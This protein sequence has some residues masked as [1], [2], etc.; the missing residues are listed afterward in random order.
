MQVKVDHV[1]GLLQP[2]VTPFLASGTPDILLKKL[3]KSY[4]SDSFKS[5]IR[6]LDSSPTMFN[7][8][9]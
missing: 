7:V 3:L 8:I 5:M 9:T 1:S 2:R 6:N 4:T